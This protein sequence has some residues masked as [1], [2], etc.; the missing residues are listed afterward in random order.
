M[1]CISFGFSLNLFIDLTDRL[2][3]GQQAQGHRLSGKAVLSLVGREL[4]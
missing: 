3:T 1:I 4:Q 2:A